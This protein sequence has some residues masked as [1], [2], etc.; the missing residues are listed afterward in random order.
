MKIQFDTDNKTIKLESEV[1]L[2][3]L[4]ETLNKLLPNGEWK[5]FTLQTN[6]VIQ[7][8]SNPVVIREYP[9]YPT[10]PRY[11]WYGM[12]VTAG[13]HTAEYKVN[14]SSLELKSGVYNV[15]T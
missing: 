5:K 2:S 4:V 11:P 6:T 15:E 9:T 13:R 14:N 10:Y 3:K 1:L 7:H 8:W 12:E